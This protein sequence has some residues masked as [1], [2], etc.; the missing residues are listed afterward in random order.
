MW[1]LKGVLSLS[2]G[3]DLVEC[4]KT[5]LFQVRFSW[6]LMTTAAASPLTAVA[7]PT[8]YGTLNPHDNPVMRQTSFSTSSRKGNWGSAMLGNVPSAQVTQLDCGHLQR[9]GV[10]M[11]SRPAPVSHGLM[12]PAVINSP[13]CLG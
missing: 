10:A 1:V 11:L 12:T 6:S 7:T 13:L 8:S 2:L 4:P 5:I 3:R 9:R